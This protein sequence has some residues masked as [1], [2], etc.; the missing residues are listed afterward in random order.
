MFIDVAEEEYQYKAKFKYH[1]NITNVNEGTK[2]YQYSNK[3]LIDDDVIEVI[4]KIYPDYKENDEYINYIAES[5]FKDNIH[6]HLN[7]KITITE[8]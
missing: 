8:Y 1:S 5:F 2:S 3:F 4:S 6:V 7:S